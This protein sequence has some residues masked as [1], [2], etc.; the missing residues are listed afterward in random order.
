MEARTRETETKVEE[1]VEEAETAGRETAVRDPACS[2]DSAPDLLHQ[3]EDGVVEDP[4]LAREALT[5]KMIAMMTLLMVKIKHLWR[6][7]VKCC[8]EN[9]PKK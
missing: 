1:G 4:V 6:R 9:L 8:K 2:P 5:R 3:V 7:N